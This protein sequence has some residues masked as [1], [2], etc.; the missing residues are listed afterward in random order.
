M[1]HL[2]LIIE[3]LT[4]LVDIGILWILWVEFNYDKIQDEKREY[5]ETQKKRKKA[6]VEQPV[7]R[8]GT[9]RVLP[10]PGGEVCDLSETPKPIQTPPLPGS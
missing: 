8:E 2:P 6:K 9:S 3:T 4:L 5:R 7:L 1:G 10:S